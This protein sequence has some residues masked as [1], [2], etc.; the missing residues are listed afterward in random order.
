MYGLK[1]KYVGRFN[2]EPVTVNVSKLNDRPSYGVRIDLPNCLKDII[3]DT[4]ACG[5]EFTINSGESGGELIF[6]DFFTGEARERYKHLGASRL[7]KPRLLEALKE[8]AP[9]VY[10]IRSIRM[11]ESRPAQ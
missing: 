5:Y 7:A 6:V 9:D 4:H 8:H 1:D 2:N 3:P 11:P 10:A